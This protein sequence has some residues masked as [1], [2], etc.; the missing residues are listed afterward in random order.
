L[1]DGAR[2]ESNNEKE[3]TYDMSRPTHSVPLW[4]AVS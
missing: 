2:G 3:Q 4:Q 1:R